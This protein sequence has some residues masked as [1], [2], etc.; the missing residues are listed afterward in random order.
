MKMNLK[1]KSIKKHKRINLNSKTLFIFLISF[2]VISIIIGISF[3]FIMSSADKSTVNNEIVKSMTVNN[4]YNY[5]KLLKE[6]ILSN[7]YNL[8]VIWILGISVIGI[9]VNIFI[10]FCQ[11]FSIGY[12]VGAIISIYKTKGIIGAIL[13]LIPSNIIYTVTLFFITYFS[14]KLSYKIIQ[15]F[16]IKKE[17]NIKIE[18]N[19][20]FKILL[21]CW[22][23]GII[24]SIL[25]VFIDPFFI[26]LFTK[27]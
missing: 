18:I 8:F 9:L 25:K 12:T 10:Y 24:S 21:F 3:Y 15:A 16:F 23:L 4:D 11:L 1:N 22:I 6:S 17:I 2:S 14:I 20:Y 19:R 27:I 26:N 5:I 7:T 13:Y